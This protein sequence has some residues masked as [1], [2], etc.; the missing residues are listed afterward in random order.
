MFNNSLFFKTHDDINIHQPPTASVSDYSIVSRKIA[1][2][3]HYLCIELTIELTWVY[4][5]LEAIAG[6]GGG[7]I[8][9]IQIK[10]VKELVNIASILAVFYQ[11]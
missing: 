3:E 1:G 7:G 2:Q 11:N 6:G 4:I 8:L 10:K 5:S 9:R